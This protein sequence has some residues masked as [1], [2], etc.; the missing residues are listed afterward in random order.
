MRQN[1]EIPAIVLNETREQGLKRQI[2]DF[3]T[4]NPE[5]IAQLIRTWLKE[6]ND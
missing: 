3:S 6:E 1:D 2:K 5:I 4:T